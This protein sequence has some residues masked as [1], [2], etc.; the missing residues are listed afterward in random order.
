M[1]QPLL[2]STSTRVSTPVLLSA[3]GVD[4]TFTAEDVLDKWLWIYEESKQ[5]GVRIIGFSTDC[6]PRYLR[7]MRIASGFF[8]SSI[9]HRFQYHSDS[10]KIKIPEWKWFL[11]ASPQ[12]F[13][14]MQ[15]SCSWKCWRILLIYSRENH[16]WKESCFGSKFQSKLDKCLIVSSFSEYLLIHVGQCASLYKTTESFTCNKYIPAARRGSD[17]YS[18]AQSFNIDNL[19]TPTWF[20]V[21]WHST[22]R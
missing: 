2:S 21:F 1:I 13:L 12:L 16:S 11:M 10:F 22:S 20:G 17:F 15:V 14:C 4:G 18:R 6:D 19:E 7:S 9:D 3:Y 5:K 8:V